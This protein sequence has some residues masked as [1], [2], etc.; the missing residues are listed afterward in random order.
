MRA[1]VQD[2][3]GPADVL[4]L[5][6]IPP[7]APG[8]GEVLVRV[9]AAGVDQGVWHV[10]TGLPYPLR[11]AGYG[12][13]APKNPVPGADLAGVVEA[14]G[15]GVTRFAPGDEV[16][17]IGMGTY[18]ELARARE[19]KLAPRP[20]R[21]TFEQAAAVAVSGLP[22]LQAPARPRQGA[23]GPEGAD[24]RRVGRRGHLRRAAGQGVRG[25]GDRR[26]RHREGRPGPLHRRRPRHRPHARRLR[27]GAA[28]PRRD[29][30]HRRQRVPVAPAARAHPEGHAR[31][32][33][34]RGRRTV[35]RG[36]RPSDPGAPA[37]AVR[38][39]E[40]RHVHLPRE[41]RGHAR[42]RRAD[43]RRDPSRRSST[44][45]TR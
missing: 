19:D 12:L 3:Y 41:P 20:A 6:D 43:R 23:P 14:V 33:R 45:P 24:R 44:G 34:R 35:A 28:A 5:R 38:G 31:H 37:V 17:G 10:M 26:V 22:A 40:A 29:P 15:A 13:R 18:A 4:E 21:L 11:L 36:H 30:R 9:R 42:P 2:T 1:I 27:A 16:F 25:G 32:R 39:P 7:P 8:A